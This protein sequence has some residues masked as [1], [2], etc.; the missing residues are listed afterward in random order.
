MKR[1]DSFFLSRRDWLRN[2]GTLGLGAIASAFVTSPAVGEEKDSLIY[3]QV[4]DSAPWSPRHGL[5]VLV[6]QDRLWVLGGTATAENGTQCNDVWSSEDG[7][8]WRRELDTAPWQPR[9]GH[10]VFVFRNKLWVIGGLASV[11]PIHNLNDIWS[12]PDGKNWTLEV[13]DAPWAARHV[14]AWT[15]HRDRMYLIGGATD[16]SRTYR[17]VIS[18]EDGVH[19]RIENIHEPWFIERKYHAAASYGDR[20]YVAGGVINDDSQL[21]GGRYLGDEWSSE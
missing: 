20:L 3:R 4:L 19:W 11:N 1:D 2:T 7:L 12:S 14:W 21:L 13:A 15:T 8:Q 18:S 16:G 17:D 10:A 9:W 6:F 5:G